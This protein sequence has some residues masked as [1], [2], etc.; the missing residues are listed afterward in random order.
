[1]SEKS[2]KKGIAA[3]DPQRRTLS[4]AEI[5]VGQCAGSTR[6]R[7]DEVLYAEEALPMLSS[8]IGI[9]AELQDAFEASAQDSLEVANAKRAI[10]EEVLAA[11]KL[12]AS[13]LERKIVAAVAELKGLTKML[14][15][16]RKKLDESKKKV[17]SGA[18]IQME[19][20]MEVLNNVKLTKNHIDRLDQLRLEFEM[21]TKR[22]KTINK[23]SKVLKDPEVVKLAVLF[24]KMDTAAK[25]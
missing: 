17:K 6:D 2:P 12:E 8:E 4:S 16:L 7:L 22:L 21:W 13:N 20:H 5:A 23:R 18:A 9:D 3:P 10:Q 1:M 25:R 11:T 14:E 19:E 24:Q 15:Q